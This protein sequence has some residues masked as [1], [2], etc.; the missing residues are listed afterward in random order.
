MTRIAIVGAGPIGL[1]AALA[2]AARSDDFDVFEAAPTVG[3][4][5]R[6]WGHVR[7][8]TPW[9][10]NVSRRMRAALPSAPDGAGLP[11]G[12]QLADELLEPV[13][14]LP[15]LR[16]RVHLR[17]RVLA[18]GRE[19]RLKHEAVGDPRRAAVPLRL[20]VTGP[21]GRETIARADVVIDASGTYANPNRLGDGGIDAVNE[22]R[23]EDRIERHLPDV[24]A[25]AR[26]WAG[27]T[28]L[29]TG[30]GHSA[31]TAARDLAALAR[32]APGTRVIWAVRSATPDWYAL[33]RDPLRE[34]A[35][36]A[37]AAAQLA[38]GAS[39]AVTVRLGFVTDALHGHGDRI[40]VALRNGH[41]REVESTGSSR[42]TAASAT[43][44]STAG[45]R[46]TSATPPPG[47]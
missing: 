14:A 32:D 4:H 25:Q 37:A 35:A 42:S 29:L 44:R 39:E 47:R 3:G 24:P 9:A 7:T 30:A 5:V 41:V 10:M 20:F 21:D 46:C 8:F 1:E 36:L 19:G 18:V 22:R 16:D 17:T 15:A 23:F 11:T 27:R 38:A 45:C 12:E 34:R 2:A 28:I 40:A 31:Q 26:A 6:R 43:T 33:A 13:A